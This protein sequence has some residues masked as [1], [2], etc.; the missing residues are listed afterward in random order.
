MGRV[1]I[2]Y[3]LN[4]AGSGGLVPIPWILVAI[5]RHI[6]VAYICEP[7]CH[8]RV[9]QIG[10]LYLY[11]LFETHLLWYSNFLTMMYF[12]QYYHALKRINHGRK[13]V[14]LQQSKEWWFEGVIQLYGLRDLCMIN[15]TT[16]N[17]GMLSTFVE[18]WH[19]KIS[20]FHLLHSEM[21]ITL[22]D[23][24]C[25]LHLLI[26]GRLLYQFRITIVELMHWR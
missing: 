26:S 17:H 2:S 24:S 20:P 15:Y 9:G 14:R 22:D 6:F 12:L 10:K 8:A 16:I 23:V 5:P 1:R 25:L 18:W 4:G 3:L 21:S 7:C 11:L 13:I 19:S